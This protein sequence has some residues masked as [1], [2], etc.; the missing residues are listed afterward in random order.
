MTVS[1]W[2]WPSTTAPATRSRARCARIAAD[3]ASGA[4]KPEAITEELIG[5]HLDAPD[6][7]RSRPHHPHQRRAAA[8]E[9]PAVAGRLFGARV[10]AG[11]LAGLRSR[12]ARSRDR[13]VSPPRAPVRRACRQDRILRSW[14]IPIRPFVPLRARAIS[15]ARDLVGG[16]CAARDPGR[17]ARR[18][19]VRH[20]LDRRGLRSCCGNGACWS[21]AARHSRRRPSPAGWSPGSSTRARCCSRRSCCAAIA[22]LGLV[23]MLFLFAIVWATDIAAYF[24]GRAI[25]GPKLWPAVSPKKTWSGAVGGTLGGVVAGL[26]VDQGCRA[27]CRPNAGASG[28]GPFGRRRRP[29]TC[30]N[31]RSSAISA[32]RMRASSSPAMAG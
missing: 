20:L 30:S 29:A 26:A 32:P 2:W 7:A 25:G 14:P 13:G 28:A 17:V 4:L 10:H 5:Q 3:V 24:A 31:P 15:P 12:G 11:L 23:A 21:E 18:R 16:A 9:L 19:D 6:I 1:R 22:A 8:V 27:C